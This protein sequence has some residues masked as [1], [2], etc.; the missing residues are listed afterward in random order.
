MGKWLVLVAVLSL[1]M[2]ACDST[3]LTPEQKKQQVE[4]R[5]QSDLA[6]S[7]AIAAQKHILLFIKFPHDATFPWSLGEITKV[8]D[9][10]F[11]I[12]STVVAK[13]LM[14]AELTYEWMAQ[15]KL[16]GSIWQLQ[17]AQINGESVFADDEILAKAEALQSGK[18]RPVTVEKK[19][20]FIPVRKEYPYRTWTDTTGKHKTKAKFLSISNGIVRLKKVDGKE[21]RLPLEKLSDADRQWLKNRKRHRIR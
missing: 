18:S 4:E 19:R 12:K 1:G 2:V 20:R 11:Q 14:G 9:G 16:V 15:E 3:P 7:A 6:N 13:N 17:Y 10:I 21:S 8:G 5:K